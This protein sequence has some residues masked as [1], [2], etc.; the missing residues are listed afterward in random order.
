MGRPP[1]LQAGE[2]AFLGVVAADSGSS[3]SSSVAVSYPPPSRLDCHESWRL[4]P[5]LT[6]RRRHEGL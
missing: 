5:L 2:R 3:N 6:W 1:L 4:M